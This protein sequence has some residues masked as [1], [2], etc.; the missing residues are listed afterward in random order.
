MYS[1]KHLLGDRILKQVIKLEGDKGWTI[2]EFFAAI[3]AA[4][5]E[6]IS[7]VEWRNWNLLN[8]FQDIDE[9]PLSIVVE[10]SEKSLE[11]Q[12]H[13]FELLHPIHRLLDV[14]C[15]NTGF[16]Q[17]VTPISEWTDKH[18]RSAT[19]HL[20]P[21]V[22]TPKFKQE[23]IEC[24]TQ[25]RAFEISDHLKLGESPVSI[26]SLSAGCL[27]PLLDAPQLMTGLV[28]R[29]QQI[30]PIHPVTLEPTPEEN[31][32]ELVRHL[33]LPLEELG[34]VMLESVF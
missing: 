26:D 20:H 21:Q 9:L 19:V 28:K 33:L 29:W 22:R 15:G 13:L 11:E 3:R 27:L 17:A 8:L 23:L 12:L 1:R 30:R 32:F 18:W 14:W 16:T 2:P 10:M 5:L 4:D 7:M 31:A 34:Y 24:V 25:L 6:F